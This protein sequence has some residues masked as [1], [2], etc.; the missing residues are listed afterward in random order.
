MP[1]TLVHALLPTACVASRKN[2][3]KGMS[4]KQTLLFLFFC[5]VIGNFPDLDVI[6]VTLFPHYESIIH[7]SIGHNALA[8]V[9][10]IILGREMLSRVAPSVFNRSRSLIYSTAL[11]VSH[12]LLDCM[13][14]KSPGV[15]AGVP[16]FWPFSDWMLE[17]PI[18]FFEG[19]SL[20]VNH[21][22]FMGHVLASDY[23]TRAILNEMVVSV[24]FLLI[25]VVLDRLLHRF[26]NREKPRKETATIKIDEPCPARENRQAI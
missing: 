11:V 22:W 10:W 21:N 18:P 4:R 3:S 5:S 23:W 6:G 25:F 16:I 9:V 8:L 13:C 7:R 2:F 20:E 15:P 17:S 24:C 26:F 1:S 14:L 19:Y 12:G